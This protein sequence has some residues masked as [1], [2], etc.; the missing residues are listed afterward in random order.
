MNYTEE[1]TLFECMGDMLVG[2][3]A[4]P[5]TP[6]RTGLVV[7][8]GGPQYR[9]GSHRQFVLLSRSLAEA[10]CAV[11]RF[12]YRGMGDSTGDS[13]DFLTVND[14]IAAA[15]SA[16]QQSIPSVEKISLWGLCDGASAALLYCGKTNDQRVSGLCLLNPWVRSE[17]SLARTYIKH[18]YAQRL[19]NKEFWRK[20]LNGKMS[21]EALNG[22]SQ[23]I[24]LSASGSGWLSSSE[25]PFQN[26][27]AMGW[28]RFHGK[29]L[30]ILSAGDLVAK[31]FREVAKTDPA[32][33]GALARV[34][35]KC[36]DLNGVDHTFSSAASRK[37]AENLSIDWLEHTYETND[38][39]VPQC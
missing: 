2:I 31:E 5:K 4:R 36:Q 19:L 8:V 23:S 32:W 35:L 18:Y 12:D 34:T 22:L 24:R 1:V 33:R 30:L 15:I 13:R 25:Q 21:L 6:A 26:R 11:M 37:M 10:G 20:L 3:L 38:K 9:A 28:N 16:L 27:M 39:V 29:I 7:I 17:V 14:D